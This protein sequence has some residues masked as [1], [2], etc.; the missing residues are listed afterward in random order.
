[1]RLSVKVLGGTECSLEAKDDYTV[2]QLK[3]DIE[4]KLKLGKAEQ[5]LLFK[6]KTLQDG[7]PL[8]AY[9]ITDGAKLNLILKREAATPTTKSGPSA[10]NPRSVD[11]VGPPEEELFKT[12]RK[13][14]ATD[15]ETKRVV[16]TFMTVSRSRALL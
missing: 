13:H 12:L 7:T 9:K 1:M 16:T 4:V 15:T 5:K 6:G 8:S 10:Q 11:K 3:K 14:F 2:E